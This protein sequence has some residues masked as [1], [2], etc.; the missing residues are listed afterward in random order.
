MSK[1]E[2]VKESN[3]MRNGKPIYC[4]VNGWDCDYYKDGVCYI[5]NPIEDC[6]D[7]AFFF[8]SWEEY[9]A[10]GDDNEE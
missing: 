9:D 1:K 6:E 5:A 2:F 8:D 3:G 10:C 4:T 7:F